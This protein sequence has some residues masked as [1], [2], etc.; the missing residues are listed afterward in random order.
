MAA[1]EVPHGRKSLPTALGRERWQPGPATGALTSLGATPRAET[2]DPRRSRAGPRQSGGRQ[3]LAVAKVPAEPETRCRRRRLAIP[4]RAGPGGR[5]HDPV[6]LRELLR[7]RLLPLLHHLQ[8]QRPMLF[9]ATFFPTWEGGI[10]DFIGEFMKASVDVADLIGLNLVMSRNAG[11]GEYKI[12]VAALGW[13]TAEL[14][15]SRC[16]P[17][18]VGARGIEFD[19]KYIQMSID[20]N[21]SLVH[22]IVASAQVWMI[23]R[24]DLYHTFRPAVLLLMF[25]SVYKAF[26]METF[27]HLCSLGSW[28]ALLARAVVTGLLALSTLAL[29]VAVVNVHS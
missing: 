5:R 17:L 26:V 3:A 9:L 14:I 13:A 22:Y 25:L 23:T 10:Y 19:W 27:V 2:T 1:G 18:W 4:A 20:S 11:K 15:M 29:Y 28:T 16:I 7:S 8:V 12:M 6:S 24:Y 21:I